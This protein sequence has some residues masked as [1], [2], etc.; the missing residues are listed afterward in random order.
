MQTS[1]RSVP[2]SKPS[3][4]SYPAIAPWWWWA[5]PLDFATK[6]SSRRDTTI[7]GIVLTVVELADL[8]WL[9]FTLPV[10]VGANVAFAAYDSGS[11][12]IAAFIVGLVGVGIT[13]VG[14]QFVVNT[15]RSPF[16][17]GAVSLIFAMPAAPA[18]YSAIGLAQLGISAH[19]WQHVMAVSGA[20]SVD[21]ML[22]RPMLNGARSCLS[23]PLTSA[24]TD[25]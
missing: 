9:L 4:I 1:R 17:R 22:P 7:I 11:G 24:P 5:Q 19:V 13:R 20:I 15:V 10:F 18:G 25:D 16:V 21:A 23:L 14:A 3:D 8:C 12:P 2:S 6:R